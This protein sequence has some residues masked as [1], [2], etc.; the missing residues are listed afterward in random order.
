[1]LTIMR[2]THYIP[3]YKV[4]PLEVGRIYLLSKQLLYKSSIYQ[5]M[6][7][8]VDTMVCKIQSVLSKTS[9]S[10]RGGGQESALSPHIMI[11]VF[12]QLLSHGQLFMFPWT[13]AHHASLSFTVSQNLLKLKPLIQWCHPTISS[14]ITAQNVQVMSDFANPWT[15]ASSRLCPW[16]CPSKNT[17]VGC[18][19]L[20]QGIFLTRGLNPHLLCLLHWQAG[21][22]L[23]APPGKPL[24]CGECRN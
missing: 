13:A 4:L 15:V 16:G 12:V 9:L 17:G 8:T 23:L 22:L 18:H 3:A 14:S 19:F 5:H 1:M 21:S 24:Y 11:V 2:V 7:N 6:L 20:F 10:G